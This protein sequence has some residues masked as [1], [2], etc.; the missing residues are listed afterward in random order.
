VF[1]ITLLLFVSFA[2]IFSA[3]M[4]DADGNKNIAKDPPRDLVKLSA[5]SGET[6]S[7]GRDTE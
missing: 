6:K 5:T 3:V 7:I 1:R 4:P 2:F